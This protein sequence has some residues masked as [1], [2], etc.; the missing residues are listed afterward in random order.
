[1]ARLDG[2][3][4][5]IT[6]AASGIGAATARLFATEGAKVVLADV[7]DAGP[8]AAEIGEAALAVTLDVRQRDAWTVVVEQ[9]VAHFGGLHILVNNAGIMIYNL[10]GDYTEEEIRRVIDINLIGPIFG[11]QAA[12]PAIEAAGGGAIVNVSSVDGLTVHNAMAPYAAS[13]WGVRGFT[14]VA[15]LELTHRGIRVNSVHPGG[16]FTALANPDGSLRKSDLDKNLAHNPIQRLAFPE[17]VAAAI[18][19][20]AGPE[21]SYSTGSEVTVDGGMTAGQYFDFLP[22]TPPALG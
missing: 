18:L 9:A 2:K 17:E 8:L 10:I 6:G 15:A 16:V 13:K 3:V 5:L 21:S 1:M 20:L 4:A 14:K 22:G 11:V 12:A 7:A 19:F